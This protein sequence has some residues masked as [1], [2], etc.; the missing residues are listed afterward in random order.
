[1]TCRQT[2]ELISRELDVDL[3]RRQRMGLRIHMIICSACRRLRR[4]LGIVDEAVESYFVAA[5]ADEVDTPLPVGVR[6][7]LEAAIALRLEN[8]S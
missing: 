3:S 2:A 1:M 6:E 4:Q 5:H 7:R 8:E